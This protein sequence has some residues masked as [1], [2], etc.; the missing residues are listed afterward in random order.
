MGKMFQNI[1]L[2]HTLRALQN[3][4]YRLYC[5]GQGISLV[6]TWAQRVA[7]GWLVYRLTG[8]ALMLGIVGFVGDIPTAVFAPIAGVLADRLDRF[9][10]IVLVQSLAMLQAFALAA[11]VLADVVEIWH[12]LVLMFISGLL[13][14]FDIPSRQ[15]FMVELIERREDISNAV[16]LNSSLVTGARLI[17]P[18]IAGLL[19]ATVGEGICF[20]VNA[21]S[22]FAVI[23]CLIAMKIKPFQPAAKKSEVMGDLKQ[24]VSYVFGFPP[25]RSIV[26][27]LGL[28][29]L[30]GVPYQVLMPIFAKDILQGGPSTLGFLMGASG[31]GAFLGA[32]YLASRRSIWGLENYIAVATWIFGIALLAFAFSSMLWL[33]LLLMV[34]TGFGMMSQMASC[35]T[36]LQ[37]LA[38]DDKRGRVLSFYAIAYRGM[39]PVGCFMAGVLADSIGAPATLWIGGVC[40]LG[41]GA[42]YTRALPGLRAAIHEVFTKFGFPK[43]DVPDPV[44]ASEPPVAL[45]E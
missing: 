6:G 29:S 3:R 23:G 31:A 19:I 43:E 34:V 2:S 35:N 22:Y 45:E 37:S 42:W 20:L 32:F 38:E 40:V 21:V 33:S 12:I 39:Y 36:M 9:R 30:M 24:G 5:Y 8:S 7:V 44:A 10:V 18:S 13:T 16:A 27:L 4:N 41:G 11:L 25:M 15:S 28:V 1:D 26:L 14:A 17:G